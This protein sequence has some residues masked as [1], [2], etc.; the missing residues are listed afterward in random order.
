MARRT[1]KIKRSRKVRR[2]SQKRK[3]RSRRVSRKRK[4]RSRRVSQKRK[5]RSRRVSRKI[6]GGSLDY[7]GP[8]RRPTAEE[9]A[10]Q[11]K[12]DYDTSR[13][14]E[15]LAA[16][17]LANSPK[18]VAT[19]PL[20][21]AEWLRA[22]RPLSPASA[23]E[24]RAREQRVREQ[25]LEQVQKRLALARGSVL[26]SGSSIAG[27]DNDVLQQIKDMLPIAEKERQRKE[28][29][30]I[31]AKQDKMRAK[32]EAE[33][34]AKQEAEKVVKQEEKLRLD[35]KNE[36]EKITRANLIK[37]ISAIGR[38]EIPEVMVEHIVDTYIKKDLTK[39][40]LTK[41][42]LTKQDFYKKFNKWID[43]VT[44]FA[45]H[46]TDLKNIGNDLFMI[47]GFRR[48]YTIID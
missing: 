8:L 32:Q 1:R 47:Y 22:R 44:G 7:G 35:K 23:R 42:E 25:R 6:K 18:P 20:S 12:H 19:P 37:K 16:E 48:K 45:I 5:S 39:Q 26:G 14:R 36:K 28:Q 40:D 3:S 34:V 21:G 15:K 27:A 2:V 17:K 38:N 33:K 41:Q 30:K 11:Y 13:A 4:S 24:Q 31:R 43:P 9:T 10:L 46:H 29:D